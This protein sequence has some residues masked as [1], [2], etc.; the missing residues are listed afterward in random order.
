[1]EF[2]EKKHKMREMLRDEKITDEEYK[3]DLDFIKAQ[4]KDID[5]VTEAIDWYSEMMKITDIFEEDKTILVNGTLEAKRDLL[6]RLGSNLVWNDEK[7]SIYCKRSINILIEGIKRIRVEYPKFEPKNY[8]MPQCLNERIGVY[9]PFY[10]SLLQTWDNVRK[11]VRNGKE[12][13]F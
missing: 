5:E 11:E 13:N 10:S 8:H 7:L 6:S 2:E 3:L 1:M 4:Y 12:A 9:F